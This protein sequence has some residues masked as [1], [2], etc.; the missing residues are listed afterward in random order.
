MSNVQVF[1]GLENESLFTNLLGTN[2]NFNI[3]S[4]SDYEYILFNYSIKGIKNSIKLGISFRLIREGNSDKLYYYDI[5][6][7]SYR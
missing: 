2:D 1:V 3:K 5:W 7:L 6:V 4:Y